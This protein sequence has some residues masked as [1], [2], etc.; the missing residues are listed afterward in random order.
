MHWKC[1]WKSVE[2][3]GISALGSSQSLP[4]IL[5]IFYSIPISLCTLCFLFLHRSSQPYS[6]K[7]QKFSCQAVFLSFLSPYQP[8]FIFIVYRKS[9]MYHFIVLSLSSAFPVLVL[10]CACPLHFLVPSGTI[11]S[12]S[13]FTFL[14]LSLSLVFKAKLDSESGGTW[15]WK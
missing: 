15:H 4:P 13:L 5:P 2:E 14:I 9:S 10:P 3:S 1:L 6:H 11:P 7:L 12:L 8:F